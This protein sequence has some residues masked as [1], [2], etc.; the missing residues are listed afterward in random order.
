MEGN[1]APMG[2]YR[3]SKHGREFR[4]LSHVN[5]Q[6]QA[7]ASALVYFFGSSQEFVGEKTVSGL[8]PDSATIRL[9]SESLDFDQKGSDFNTVIVRLKVL[10]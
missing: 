1:P 7:G 5:R 2:M 9:K 6:T 4:K 3:P 8:P 10:N